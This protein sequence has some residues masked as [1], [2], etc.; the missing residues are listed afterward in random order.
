M[1]TRLNGL[2]TLYGVER[3]PSAHS[4]LVT[5]ARSI[6]TAVFD[7]LTVKIAIKLPIKPMLQIHCAP[8]S[9]RRKNASS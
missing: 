7:K 2:E 3:H 9:I 1:P 8:T 4:L 6:D 5:N